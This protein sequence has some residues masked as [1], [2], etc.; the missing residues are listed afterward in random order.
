MFSKEQIKKYN[1]KFIPE[2]DLDELERELVGS[3][4][5]VVST[6]RYRACDEVNGMVD[7]LRI[8]YDDN[9]EETVIFGCNDCPPG[10]E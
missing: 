2:R 1:G 9:S 8:N 3:I 4:D 5:G 10:K 7:I 6:Y